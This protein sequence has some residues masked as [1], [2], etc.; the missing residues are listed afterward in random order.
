MK[1]IQDYTEAVSYTHLDVY[2][3]QVVREDSVSYTV[4]KKEAFPSVSR[5][6]PTE[7][8]R[9]IHIQNPH[10]LKIRTDKFLAEQ[11]SVSRSKIK[12]L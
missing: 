8:C 10:D 11:L 12:R 5:Q 3:R 7:N 6:N 1:T 4:S 9:M 2:K